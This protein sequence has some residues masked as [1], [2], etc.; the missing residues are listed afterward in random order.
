[1]NVLEFEMLPIGIEKDCSV[2]IG[3]I[4]QGRL[5]LDER[6]ARSAEDFRFR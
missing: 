5:R 6:L 2:A 4:W 1:M 3:N